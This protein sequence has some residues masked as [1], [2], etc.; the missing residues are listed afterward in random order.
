MRAPHSSRGLW[1]TGLLIMAA[2]ALAIYF[3]HEYGN[4]LY[5]KTWIRHILM[6]TVIFSGLFF[7]SASARWWLHR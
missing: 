1:I 7:I 6:V 4:I 2:G 3:V 5:Q